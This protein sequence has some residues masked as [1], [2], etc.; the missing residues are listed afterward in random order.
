MIGLIRLTFAPFGITSYFM[1]V[2]NVPLSS[3]MVG[4]LMYFINCCTQSFIGCSLYTPNSSD[5][6]HLSPEIV[7]KH[8]RMTKVTLIVEITMT[9][10]VT[11]LI[12]YVAKNIL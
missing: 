1:G 9:L 2:T 8:D 5:S 4:N 3:Y 11:V 10:A 7:A 6:K 12:G